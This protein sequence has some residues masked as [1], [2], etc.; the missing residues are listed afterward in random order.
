[1][2]KNKVKILSL[3]FCLSITYL[4]LKPVQAAKILNFTDD[5]SEQK[6]NIG[7]NHEISFVSPSGVSAGQ[8]II[9]TFAP[10]YTIGA[11]DW[12]DIDL[13][14]DNVDLDLANTPSA[15][16][17]GANF[18]GNILTLRSGTGVIAPNSN[19]TIKIGDSDIATHQGNGD[20]QIINPTIKG[21]YAM[22]IGGTFGDTGLGG[23]YITEDNNVY[24]RAEVSASSSVVIQWATPEL[25]VGLPETNDEATFFIKLD[26]Q[27]EGDN[28]VLFTQSNLANTTVAGT[29]LT[30]IE[31]SVASG[32]Y[33]AIIKTHQHISKKLN[34]VQI[35][36]GLT[37]LNF[38]QIDNSTPKGSIRLLAGDINLA[39]NSTTTLGDDLIDIPNDLTILLSSIDNNDPTGNV[40]RA[41]LNQDVVVNSVDVSILI[42]NL[43]LTGDSS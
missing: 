30:P 19:I 43:G 42:K 32:T 39:G 6:I 14:D 11:V 12:T 2:F 10:E 40:I 16:T 9:I 31:I 15:A 38:T 37:V 36:D 20:Q 3:I 17:W 27:N 25:R 41:N 33:D 23:T 13:E 29:Y 22:I 21:A 7:S 5:L 18:T 26:T 1:M 4:A 35:T 34:D 28:N 24:I 8:T